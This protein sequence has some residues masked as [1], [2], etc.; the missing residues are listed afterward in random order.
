[1]P[2]PRARA[3][4]L[5]SL[6]AVIGL[7]G[8]WGG[9]TFAGG[10]HGKT[11]YVPAG[12]APTYTVSA[13]PTYSL[14]AAS[15][16]QRLRLAASPTYRLAAAPTYQVATA[17]A[18]TYQVATAAAPT[19]QVATAAAPT[20]Q[21][22]TVAAPTYQVTTAAA[23][24]SAKVAAAPAGKEQLYKWN[25]FSFV[26]AT[27]SGGVAASPGVA[28]A[29]GDQGETG[30]LSVSDYKIVVEKLKAFVADLG[31]NSNNLSDADLRDLLAPRAQDLYAEYSGR[32]YEDFNDTDRAT[33]KGLIDVALG[34]TADP[35]ASQPSSGSGTGQAQA[36]QV[37]GTAAPAQLFLPVRVKHHHLRPF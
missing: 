14:V 31:S 20:Y 13:A 3:L 33:V 25:G 12:A 16:L 9:A 37:Q 28:A 2:N 34:T 29:P 15:P 7:L 30:L 27:G 18:P 22:M 11:V 23:A 4:G 24:P 17:A 21:V 1:M 6:A 19:Y 10:L 35:S 26:P 36:G 5:R 8:S 32:K